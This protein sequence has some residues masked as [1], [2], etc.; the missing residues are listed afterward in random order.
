FSRGAGMRQELNQVIDLIQKE[1]AQGDLIF[2]TAKSLKLSSQ[3]G[4]I[5]EYKVSI[6]Q[7]VG[8]RTIKEGRVGISY[9]ESMDRE[10]LKLMVME[11]LKNG[12]V[13]ESNPWERILPTSGE[14]Q[15]EMDYPEEEI[16]VSAKIKRAQELES[17]IRKSDFR[18]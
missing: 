10:S 16:D 8:V 2:S 12:E 6:S 14:I 4:E 17:R 3:N 11:S 1:G 7:V 5:S 15:D 9:S 18:V 13:T